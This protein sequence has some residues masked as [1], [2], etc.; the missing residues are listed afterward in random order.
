MTNN[1]FQEILMYEY[2]VASS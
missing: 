2:I 1:G